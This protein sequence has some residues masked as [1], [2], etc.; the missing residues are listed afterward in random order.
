MDNI[1]AVFKRELSGYFETPVAYVL[2]VVF[3]LLSGIFTFYVGQFYE[4]GQ[5]DLQS[6][7]IWQIWLYLFLI[8]AV[9]M[10]LWAEEKK[11]GTVELLMTL[12]ITTLEAVLGKY[13][14]AWCFSSITLLLTFPIWLTVSYLGDPDNGIIFLSYVGSI[15]MAGAFLAIGSCVS[16]MT[17]N[18][19]I[20]FV[21]SVTVCFLFIVSGLSMMLDFFTSLGFPQ[22]I[23]STVSSFS[24][25]TNFGDI[26]KG[27][28]S[29]KNFVFFS[30]LIVFWLFL[31]VVILETKRA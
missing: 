24:F 21:V 11:S 5:A 12:P 30:S 20:S 18:Q 28:L 23:V 3:L 25:L 16:A 7:F 10:R 8:P 4:S 19:V 27:L 9:S 31:N 13:F 14:A 1:L 22:I 29:L 17:K 26:T 6:F 2:I 15:I